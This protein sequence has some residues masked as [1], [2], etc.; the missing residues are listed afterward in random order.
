MVVKVPMFR[1]GGTTM[2]LSKRFV[3]AADIPAPVSGSL[4][5]RLRIIIGCALV[6]GC[7]SGPETARATVDPRI[8]HACTVTMAT[9]EGTTDYENCVSS[10]SGALAELNQENATRRAWANC[11]SKGMAENSPAFARCVL[12]REETISTGGQGDAK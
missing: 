5:N 3:G 6:A 11:A 1:K 9:S 7:V 12:A 10:I 8:V 4:Q 2:K